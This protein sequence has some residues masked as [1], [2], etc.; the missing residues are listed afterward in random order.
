MLKWQRLADKRHF[1]RPEH[2]RKVYPLHKTRVQNNTNLEWV[3]AKCNQDQSSCDLIW[4]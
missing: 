2:V 3:A 4:Y 1:I